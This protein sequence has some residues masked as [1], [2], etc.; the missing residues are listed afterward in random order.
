MLKRAIWPQQHISGMLKLMILTMKHSSHTETDSF[1]TT[2][3]LSN[4]ETEEFDHNTFQ[5][6]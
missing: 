5:P 1:F 3:N 4:A 6:C 2:N